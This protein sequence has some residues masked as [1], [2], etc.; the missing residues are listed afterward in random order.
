MT[1]YRTLTCGGREIKWILSRKK[2]KNLNLRI[3][4]DGF[5]YVSANSRVTIGHIEDFIREKSDFILDALDRYAAKNSEPTLPA[6]DELYQ[7]GD[8]LSYFG[9]Y[10]TLSI[11]NST[12]NAVFLHN[13]EIIV[14]TKSEGN[15]GRLL[16]KFY[17][18]ETKKLFEQLN[19]RTCEMFR[20][21]GYDVPQAELQIRKMTSRWGSCHY[22]K[23][24]I[25]MNSR[26]A[27]YPEMCAAYVFIH[28]YAHFIF[29]DHSR[30]FYAVVEQLMPD[31]RICVN[32]LKY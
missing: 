32:I 12:K 15:V 3:K 22:T 14:Q 9:E 2:V 23:G 11:E 24:K 25:V 28:E 27:L 17:S 21:K 29:P 10:Y 26:L 16:E 8:T 18:E 20:A 19:R 7:N 1:D 13:K 5:V 4:P 6:A 31:Y 30:N